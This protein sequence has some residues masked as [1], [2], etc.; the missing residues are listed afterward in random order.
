MTNIKSMVDTAIEM[1]NSGEDLRTVYA[2]FCDE[3]NARG[4][5]EDTPEDERLPDAHECTCE[6]LELAKMEYRKVIG[7]E[8]P[9]SLEKIGNPR[10]FMS[11]LNKELTKIFGCGARKGGKMQVYDLKECYE[12]LGTIEWLMENGIDWSK[13]H[14]SYNNPWF[15]GE[16]GELFGV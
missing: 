3:M 16:Y 4:F 2:I 1:H 13:V 5:Y 10:L 8:P 7:L 15:L 6:M 9:E 12:H 11:K 14:T